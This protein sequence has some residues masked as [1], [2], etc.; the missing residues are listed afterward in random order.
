M[1]LVERAKKIIERKRDLFIALEEMDK[2]GKLSKLRY[3]KR[4]NFTI[5]EEVMKRFR[6]YC[7]KRGIKMSTKVEDLISKEIKQG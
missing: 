3:K 1:S 4:Q 7:R 2:T 6:D 5:D